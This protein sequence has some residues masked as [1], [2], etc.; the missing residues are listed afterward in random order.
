MN[1]YGKKSDYISAIIWFCLAAIWIFVLFYF[2]GQTGDE[3]GEL[4]GRFT[5]FVMRLFHLT[6]LNEEKFEYILR[7]LAHLGIF[8]VEGFLLRVALYHLRSR[9]LVNGILCSVFCAGL[10][11]A[12][13]YHESLT[14][15]RAC[16][17]SDMVID[18][19]GAILGIIA[20]SLICWIA[21]SV[22]I[23]KKYLNM[24]RRTLD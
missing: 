13:E 10:A 6:A 24:R 8:A 1:K 11:V 12:N 17:V 2:S 19:S 22:F 20:A 23:R 4:S 16:L 15:G 21:E 9:F 3:S 7:K 18:T 5:R 14:P